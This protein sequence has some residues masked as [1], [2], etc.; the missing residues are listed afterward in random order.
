MDSIVLELVD[1]L[2]TRYAN[3]GRTCDLAKYLESFPMDFITTMV[4]ASSF[5]QRAC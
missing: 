3:V 1:V 5:L 4:R 2:R